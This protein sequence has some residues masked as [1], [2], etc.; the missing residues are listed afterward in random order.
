MYLALQKPHADADY[1]PVKATAL[2][3]AAFSYSDQAN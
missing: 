1:E 3:N 2:H